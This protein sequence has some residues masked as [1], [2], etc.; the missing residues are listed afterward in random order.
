[1][2]DLIRPRSVTEI[3]DAAFQLY[4]RSPTEYMTVAALPYVPYLGLQ[5]LVVGPQTATP[6]FILRSGVVGVV[7]L[8]VKFL[9]G[10]PLIWLASEQYL[11]RPATALMAFNAV[12]R[13]WPRIA[14]ALLMQAIM[15]GIGFLLLIVPGVYLT[16]QTFGV[17]SVMVIEGGGVGRA[18]TRSELLSKDLKMHILGATFLTAIIY[19]VLAFA[20]TG[21]AL[22]FRNQLLTEILQAVTIIA[23]FPIVPITTTIVYYDTRIRREGFDVEWMTGALAAAPTSGPPSL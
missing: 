12:Y 20:I 19:F 23:V 6:G 2:S 5:L 10:A 1:L 3:V 18:F 17:E 11:G 14:L 8:F 16:A 22:L 21:P 7:G 15:V 9:I 13:R 4:R